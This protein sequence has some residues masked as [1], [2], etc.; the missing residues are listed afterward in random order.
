MENLLCSL[1]C[2]ESE[3]LF[4]TTKL[5][6]QCLFCLL[7]CNLNWGDRGKGK[8]NNSVSFVKYN[9]RALQSLGVLINSKSIYSQPSSPYLW[10]P[11]H[12]KALTSICGFLMSATAP[13]TNPQW[14]TR[15]EGLLI[16]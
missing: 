8:G 10:F 7:A 9:S 13:G 6:M 12:I 4:L 16:F 5:R 1:D 2:G 11:I 15:D 14:V 3:I